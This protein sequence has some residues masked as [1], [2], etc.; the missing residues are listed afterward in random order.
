MKVD[1]RMLGGECEWTQVVIDHEVQFYTLS[2]IIQHNK[3]FQQNGV[4]N[5]DD[6]FL[7]FNCEGIISNLFIAFHEK[8]TTN[9]SVNTPE[10]NWTIES[11]IICESKPEL[12]QRP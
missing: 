12:Y 8:K 5:K 11:F 1:Q 2:H 10:S 9:E 7:L 4:T 3:V 6:F